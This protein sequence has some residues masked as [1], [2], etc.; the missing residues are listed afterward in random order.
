MP[1]S[2]KSSCSHTAEDTV[3][4]KF[5]GTRESFSPKNG[6]TQSERCREAVMNNSSFLFFPLGAE[7]GAGWWAME[8]AEPHVAPGPVGKKEEFLPNGRRPVASWRH[9]EMAEDF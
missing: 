5:A 4:S 8:H 3:L 9:Q 2:P 7:V 1:G 6:H